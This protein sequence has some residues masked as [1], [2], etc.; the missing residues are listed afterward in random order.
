M[1][2][3]AGI[4]LMLGSVLFIV[5]AFTPLT[6]RVVT[7]DMQQRID[8]IQNERTGWVILNILFGTGS[9]IAAVGLALFA[10]HVQTLGGNT[11]IRVVS[12]LGAASVVLG[13]LCWV[14]I[15]Y[16]RAALPPQELGSNLSINNWIFPAYT[17]LTQIG[18]MVVG[19]VL[20]QSHYPA[21]LSWGTFVL[22]GLSIVA[23][24]I[25]K[26]MPPFVHY[27]LFLVMGIALVR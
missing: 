9:V 14:I 22:A 10:Q 5:A 16:N 27:M 26:D 24:L 6:F 19:F 23:Y 25:F 2:K 18:L 4:G 11:T 12:Y 13:A 15:V 3:I 8:L 20:I 1:Q 21:W 7:A 17:L